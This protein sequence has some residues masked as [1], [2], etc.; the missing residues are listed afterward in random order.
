MQVH[1]STQQPRRNPRSGAPPHAKQ[2]RPAKDRPG[3]KPATSR[4]QARYGAGY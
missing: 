3:Q 2:G 4:K 1:E